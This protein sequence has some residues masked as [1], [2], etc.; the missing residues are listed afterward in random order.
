MRYNPYVL[1]VRDQLPDTIEEKNSVITRQK[2]IGERW[3][4]ETEEFKNKY[5]IESNRLFNQMN[6]F[7]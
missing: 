5:R 1:Y 2:R 4:N 7:E 3:R 6:D